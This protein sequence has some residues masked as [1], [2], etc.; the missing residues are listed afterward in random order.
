MRA[1]NSTIKIRQKICVRCGKPC[2]W[3]SK[4][5]CKDCARIEDCKSKDEESQDDESV[6]NL[7]QDLDAIYSRYI[8]L[9]YAN[10][11][12]IVKCFTCDN[13]APIGQ[14][15]NGHYISRSHMATR[16]YEKNCRPQCPICNSKHE[17]DTRPF[18]DRLEEEE[19]GITTLLTEMSRE[20][21]KPT[22]DELKSLISEYR[23]KNKILE[24][25]LKK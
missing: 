4:K 20:I 6:Q 13:A 10:E 1:H 12:G 16:F 25:K 7:I 24:K 17:V 21:E 9:K 5:R 23:F 11:K 18:H 14:M 15:Q 3:F 22:R 8:R 19:P 2:Y